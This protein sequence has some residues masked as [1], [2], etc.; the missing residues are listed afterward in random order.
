VAEFPDA[1]TARG[2]RHMQELA[3]MARQGNRAVVLFLVQRTD[4]S[5][6]R[7]AGD[8]DPDYARALMAAYGAG[9]EV[10]AHGAN[11]SPKGITLGPALPVSLPLA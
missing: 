6:V 4:A 1:R 8:I 11:I 9:V 3:A 5:E 2:A 7:I 10:I